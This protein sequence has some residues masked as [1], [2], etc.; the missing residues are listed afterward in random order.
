M[1][2]VAFPS[3]EI[4][5]TTNLEDT[6][7]ILGK[8]YWNDN[9]SF[10]QLKS[11]FVCDCGKLE[12]VIPPTLLH[13]LQNLE[14]LSVYSCSSLMSEIGTDRSNTAECQ[15][16]ALRDME[17]VYLAC[18]TKIGLNSMDHSGAMTLYPKP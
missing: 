2:Q 9:V 10:C 13:R 8:Y 18:L 14:Y 15:L 11:L 4:L 16:R 3:L 6:S 1:P 5:H 12:I 7:D 17:L